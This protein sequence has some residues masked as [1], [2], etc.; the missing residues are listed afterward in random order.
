MDNYPVLRLKCNPFPAYIS[1]GKVVYHAREMHPERIFSTFVAM[2]IEEGTLYFTEGDYSYILTAGQWYIQTPG[3][4]HYGYQ[5][6]GVRTVFHFVHFL[7]QEDWRIERNREGK[8]QTQLPIQQLDSGKGIRIPKYEIDLPMRGTYPILGWKEVLERLEGESVFGTGAI[9]KQA[10]FLQLLE[11]MIGQEEKGET[12]I[13]PME[14]IIAY[15]QQHY[16]E[17]LTVGELA[18]HFHFSPDYLTRQ[19]KRATGMTPSALI[20]QH[21]MNKAKH[22]LVYTNK[23]VLEISGETGYKDLAVF[24]RMFTK[25]VGQSPT[26]YRKEQGGFS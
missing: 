11:K 13:A 17:A 25:W 16:A 26:R 9:R 18:G 6:G 22:L 8:G 15:I 1:S 5:P 10:Y 20:T 7:P 24:C 21:R 12:L 19:M 14:K 4:R 23:S 2:F 3:V